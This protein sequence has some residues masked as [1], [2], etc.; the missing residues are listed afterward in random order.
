VGTLEHV[1]FRDV[2]VFHDARDYVLPYQVWV[3]K[4]VDIH[5]SKQKDRKKHGWRMPITLQLAA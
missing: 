5:T 3:Q 4:A 2:V 1:V